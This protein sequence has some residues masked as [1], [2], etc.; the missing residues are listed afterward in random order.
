MSGNTAEDIANANIGSISNGNFSW[1]FTGPDSDGDGLLDAEELV[2][3]TDPWDIDTDDDGLSDFEEVNYAG[4]SGDSPG[5]DWVQNPDNG[6]WYFLNEVDQY[7]NDANSSA[8]SSGCNL[9][10]ITDASLD[11]WVFATFIQLEKDSW[12]GLNDYASEGNWIWSSGAISAYTNWGAG[13]P[14]NSGNEDGA[15]I[16]VAGHWNDSQNT[17]KTWSIWESPGTPST[18][19]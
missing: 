3:G 13:E 14:N 1:E 18:P 4:N 11:A 6:W 9:A 7:W 19:E 10:T 5:A 16:T 2:I 17:T 8:T 12:I 15:T